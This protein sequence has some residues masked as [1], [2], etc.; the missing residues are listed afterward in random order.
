MAEFFGVWYAFLLTFIWVNFDGRCNIKVFLPLRS[1][2]LPTFIW[3]NFIA[4]DTPEFSPH[5]GMVEI[6][7]GWYAFL[8]L[9]Y[10]WIFLRFAT[11][12][13]SDHSV[14]IASYPSLWYGGIFSRF[15]TSNHKNFFSHFGMVEFFRGL[16]HQTVKFFVFSAPRALSCDTP[17]LK[18]AI[19][20][21]NRRVWT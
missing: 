20:G 10:G 17:S 7:C 13:F 6:F 18:G 12:K 3:V 14:F 9:L 11:S 1:R 19:L 16:Q 8:S 15:A 5:F 2:S 21:Q 4:V